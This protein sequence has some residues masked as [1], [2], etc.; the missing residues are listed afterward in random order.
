MNLQSAYEYCRHKTARPGSSFYYSIL[1]Y[2]EQVRCD[3]L[4]LHAFGTELEEII[5]ECSDP[6]VMQMK[7]A[8]WQD[9]ITR[10]YQHAARHPV[11]LVLDKVISRHGLQQHQLL[12]LIS[13]LEQINSMTQLRTWLDLQKF[14]SGGPGLLW[15]LSADIC[16]HQDPGTMTLAV[17]MGSLFSCFQILHQA[18]LPDTGLV[19]QIKSSN[20]VSPVQEIQERLE[21]NCN[22]FPLVDRP[23]QL[24][25]LI[26]G[27]IIIK[28]C[29]EVLRNNPQQGQ[30]VMLTPLR[31]LWIAWRLQR[32]YR[33]T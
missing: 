16:G 9:E 21:H 27:H 28:C 17:E 10:V 3:L 7:L 32:R 29:H 25:L 30:R 5:Y 23:T 8:W 26:M 4:A 20:S 15:Q 13:N 18:V 11:G 12:Q 33:S 14:L 31:K 24:H 2:P 1:F 19:A 6:A 22:I